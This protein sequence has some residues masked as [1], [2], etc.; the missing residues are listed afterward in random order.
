MTA[1]GAPP[2]AGRRPVIQIRVLLIGTAATLLV[3]VALSVLALTRIVPHAR[4]LEDRGQS[5]TTVAVAIQVLDSSLTGTADELVEVAGQVRHAGRPAVAS[6]LQELRLRL[7]VLFDSTFDAQGKVF[8][9]ISDSARVAL[10]R[11]TVSENDALTHLMNAEIRLTLG[12]VDGALGDVEGA[13]AS[14]RQ[15]HRYLNALAAAIVAD[16]AEREIAFGRVGDQA[17]RFTVWWTILGFALVLGVGVLAYVR[18]YQPLGA[19]ARGLQELAAG[20]FRHRLA[21]RWDDELGRLQAYL[22]QV[23]ETL[24]TRSS[25]EAQHARNLSERLER[26]LEEGP[27]EIYIFDATTWRFLVTSRAARRNLGYTDPQL[28]GLTPLDL[29]PEYTRERFASVLD[30]V[31]SGVQPR[32]LLTTMQR[33]ADGSTYPVEMTILFSA[34]E[35]PPVFH[36]VVEDISERIR[37]EAERDLV[38]D[39]SADL[40]AIGRL[41]TRR[42]I[43]VNPAMTAVLGTPESELVG[44]S[45]VDV[46]HPE[47]QPLARRQLE[48]LAQGTPVRGTAVRIQAADGEYRWVSWNIE[49]PREGLIYAIGRDITDRRRAE[50]RQAELQAAVA[51]SAREWRMT[52][53]ALDDPVVIVNQAGQIVRLNE[54]AR[55]M[56]GQSHGDILGR[57]LDALE[58]AGLWKR[59]AELA[60]RVRR[61]GGPAASQL[62]SG[63]DG[64]TWDLQVQSVSGA[65]AGP[66]AAIIIAHDV[67]PVVLLQDSVRRNEAMAA[68]GALVAGVAHEVRNPLFSMT[69]TLDAFEARLSAEQTSQRHIRVL[70]TQL[71][72]LQQLMRELLEYGKPP[73]LSIGTVRFDL[74]AR[75]AIDESALVARE[76]GVTLETDVPS[77]LPLV[78]ADRARLAQVYVNLLTNAIHHSPEGA[79]VVIRA[80]DARENGASWLQT[81]VEDAGQG[82]RTDDLPRIFEPFFSRRPGGTGL[83]LAL[84]QRIVEQHGGSVAAANRSGGGAVVVVRLPLPPD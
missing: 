67:T 34:T 25:A 14:Q 4:R 66:M 74:I 42:W 56:S 68:M 16:L 13:R 7:R 71:D 28:V 69:A 44:R 18:L 9:T 24:G 79:H 61:D 73:Q 26:V 38:F 60:D 2:N 47:D 33:R 36:A 6:R 19:L 30:T 72:R 83:G 46:I 70:R 12:D 53:D 48:Q 59:A 51:R 10:V 62:R 20:N 57:R 11:A 40:M 77:H 21:V 50:T 49:P 23:A 22:N 80:R 58:P 17:L 8:G 41:D 65:G 75:Q 76:H 64:R 43:R 84:V 35:Q 39:R 37:I 1:P 5:L 3:L 31:R 29:L 82:F 45:F 78:R 27:N 52:F 63:R 54:A 32:A 81:E 55:R 15:T